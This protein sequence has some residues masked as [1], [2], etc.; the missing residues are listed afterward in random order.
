MGCA[1]SRSSPQ[2]ATQRNRFW[3]RHMLSF[4]FS[5][6][7]KRGLFTEVQRHQI[8]R[9]QATADS[10][11][12]SLTAR[13]FWWRNHYRKYW[14]SDA[15]FV[16]QLLHKILQRPGIFISFVTNLAARDLS[17]S[18]MSCPSRHKVAIGTHR[19]YTVMLRHYISRI[20]WRFSTVT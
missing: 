5:K 20:Y 9:H 19:Q 13:N 2:P 7:G 1:K 17:L 14:S 3:Q 8:A 15:L 11:F 6:M 16:R 4:L 10:A 12:F 18:R